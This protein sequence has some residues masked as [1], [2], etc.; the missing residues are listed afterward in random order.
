[1][2]S[3]IAIHAKE[4]LVIKSR[5]HSEMLARHTGKTVEQ[6]ERDADRDNFMSADEAKAYGMVD[7]VMAQRPSE[8]V[9]DRLRPTAAGLRAGHRPRCART[10]L[11]LP[12]LH[13]HSPT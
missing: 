4:I 11:I 10:R 3:D 8:S 6:I 5:L 7:A 13:R 2:A 9:Q 12:G 1:M